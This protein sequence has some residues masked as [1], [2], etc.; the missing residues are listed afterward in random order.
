MLIV[1]SVAMNG[2]IAAFETRMPLNTPRAIPTASPSAII[3]IGGS[4]A[5]APS[6][7][8]TPAQRGAD[9]SMP[10]TMRT[11]FGETRFGGL[12]PTFSKLSTRRKWR[13]ER[14]EHAGATV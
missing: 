9:K 2:G 5:R 8:V 10:A 13:R 14:E 6:P 3:A 12:E 7:M 4:P 11:S 1:A